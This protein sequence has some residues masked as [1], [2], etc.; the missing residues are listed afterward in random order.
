MIFIVEGADGSGKSTLIQILSDYGMTFKISRAVKNQY[1][2]WSDLM[3]VS[4]E[5]NVNFIADRCPLTDY[6]YR[7]SEGK[8]SEYTIDELIKMF[9]TAQ[10]IY[11]E[12]DT[13]FQD[14]ILRGEDFVT[15]FNMAKTISD[16]YKYVLKILEQEGVIVHRYNWKTD[17]VNELLK[18]LNLV[19]LH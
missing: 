18:N 16:T 1:R 5:R 14:S 9:K 4:L 10:L 6:V 13:Q 2:L 15:D 7:M 12:T 3:R 11:C 8:R 19:K 17:D